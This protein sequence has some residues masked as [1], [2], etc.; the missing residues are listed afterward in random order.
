[1]DGL[2]V[3]I[4]VGLGEIDA[5]ALHQADHGGGRKHVFLQ[6]ARAHVQSRHVS[7]AARKAGHKIAFHDWKY[8]G[9][10]RPRATHDA[11][12]DSCYDEEKFFRSRCLCSC[13]FASTSITVRRPMMNCRPGRAFRSSKATSSKT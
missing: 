4:E 2:L 11:A 5:G 13:R 9:E 6:L 12:S 8:T 10:P 3:R 7:R 1:A